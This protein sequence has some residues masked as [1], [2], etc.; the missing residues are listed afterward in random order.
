[1]KIDMRTEGPNEK[2]STLNKGYY[3]NKNPREVELRHA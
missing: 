2:P 1:M 3:W